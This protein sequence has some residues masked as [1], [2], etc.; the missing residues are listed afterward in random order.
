MEM[1]ISLLGNSEEA[2]VL[3]KSQIVVFT[4]DSCLKSCFQ[5]APNRS[6]ERRNAHSDQIEIK[7]SLL[8]NN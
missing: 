4:C 5:E 3:A 6:K 8:K 7:M 1:P 2:E